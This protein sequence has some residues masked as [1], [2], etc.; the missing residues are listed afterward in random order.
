MW[1]I[2]IILKTFTSAV[3]D[4]KLD[5][6]VHKAILEL[7]RPV[8]SE[9]TLLL[10]KRVDSTLIKVPPSAYT[11]TGSS[12]PCYIIWLILVQNTP[13]IHFSTM[14]NYVALPNLSLDILIN[15][16]FNTTGGL[17]SQ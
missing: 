10:A 9:L 4:R 12:D 14:S 8:P 15:D 2:Y 1:N 5:G 13:I 11:L 7:W 3:Q 6:L 16:S 17:I